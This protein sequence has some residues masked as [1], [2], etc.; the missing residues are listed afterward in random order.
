VSDTGLGAWLA[1]RG[2]R[3]YRLRQIRRHAA[4][5]SAPDWTALTDL[6]TALRE[7]RRESGLRFAA[8]RTWD[9]AAAQ[10]E[11]G[12]REALRVAAL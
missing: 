5:T 4:R 10:V 2:E 9:R 6:P 8:E 12:L 3:Q 1:A 7:A 11:E